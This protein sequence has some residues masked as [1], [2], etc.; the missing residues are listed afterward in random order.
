MLWTTY[1]L[2]RCFIL[3]NILIAGLSCTTS[4]KKNSNKEKGYDLDKV[5]THKL[6][7]DL[8]D[9]AKYIYTIINESTTEVEVNGKT[10]NAEHKSNV[11]ITYDVQKDSAGNYLL[12]MHFN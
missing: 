7:I 11:A 4:H 10:V 5:D 1:S 3:F 9:G 2:L 12:I 8:A 6:K